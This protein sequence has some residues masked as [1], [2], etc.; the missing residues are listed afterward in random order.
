MWKQWIN[1]FLGLATIGLAF[2]TG[3]ADAA[4]GWTIGTIG[5]IVLA[6]S[7][8]TIAKTPQEKHE[9]AAHEQHA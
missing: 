1:A 7:A 9:R 5:A 6:L 3:I 4:L 2:I 8:G